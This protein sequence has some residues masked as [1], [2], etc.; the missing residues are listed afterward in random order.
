VKDGKFVDRCSGHCPRRYRTESREPCRVSGVPHVRLALDAVARSVLDSK[1]CT[2]CLACPEESTYPVPSM[3]HTS[4][5]THHD[6]DK[7]LH[8]TMRCDNR[9][10]VTSLGV[11]VQHNVYSDNLQNL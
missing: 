9:S 8:T 1:R 4:R 2:C 6:P 11:T 5:S 7:F 3:M 10:T